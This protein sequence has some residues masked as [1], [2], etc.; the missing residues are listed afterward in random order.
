MLPHGMMVSK[1]TP[2]S[3]REGASLDIGI[4][5]FW[6]AARLIRLRAASPSTRTWYSLM[7]ALVGETTSWS[8]LAPAMFLGQSEASKPIDVSIHLWWGAT[9]GVGAAA[10]TARCRVLT[11]GL[12]L[13]S[14]EPSYMMWSYL[15]RSSV[16]E[17]ESE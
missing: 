9:L 7:L 10:A 11:T 15:R 5:G 4:C 6:K 16:L 1:P 2:K 14:Q 3:G 17:L 8:C 13:M 12:D